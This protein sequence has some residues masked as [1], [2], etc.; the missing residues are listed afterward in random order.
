[1]NPNMDN[2]LMEWI[3]CEEEVQCDWEEVIC[4]LIQ[5]KLHVAG[6]LTRLLV[7]ASVNWCTKL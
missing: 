2:I 1:M 5:G 3:E 4:D 7:F 6:C